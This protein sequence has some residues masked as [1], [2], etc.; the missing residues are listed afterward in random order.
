MKT[1]N[2]ILLALFGLAALSIVSFVFAAKANDIPMEDRI[3]QAADEGL[4][5]GNN[6]VSNIQKTVQPFRYLSVGDH[7]RVELVQ[8]TPGKV[9]VNGEENIIP[10]IELTE[11]NDTLKLSLADKNFN[12]SKPL[13]VVVHVDESLELIREA[14]YSFVSTV[15]AITLGDIIIQNHGHNGRMELNILAN[16]L[17]VSQVGGEGLLDIDGTAQSLKFEGMGSGQFDSRD[18]SITKAELKMNGAYNIHVFSSDSLSLDATGKGRI[19]YSGNPSQ[20]DKKLVGSIRLEEI[21]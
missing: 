14:D 7:I 10:L 15:G 9:E 20:I 1:S 2:K 3:Q 8:G 19:R 12:S 13:T 16:E 18:L 21:K 5:I 11:E 6:K 4:V 17:S